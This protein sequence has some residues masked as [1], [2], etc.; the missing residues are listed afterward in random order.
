MGV[1]K[2][3]AWL[4]AHAPQATTVVKLD[5]FKGYALAV[6]MDNLIYKMLKVAQKQVIS[7]TD[8]SQDELDE[9][10]LNNLT[11]R[12][13]MAKISELIEHGITPVCVFD[14]PSHPLK[15]HKANKNRAAKEKLMSR[16]EEAKNA[17]RSADPLWRSQKLVDDYAK[18][19]KQATY[20]SSSFSSD[21]YHMLSALGIPV[22]KGGE[23]CVSHIEAKDAEGLCATLC[24][25]KYCIAAYTTDS[26]FHF[27]GGDTQITD[28][29]HGNAT[30][31]TLANILQQ[32]QITYNQ[33][34]DMCILLG[35]DFNPNIRGIALV[36]AW[37]KLQKYGSI[38]AMAL[39]EDVSVLNHK[40]VRALVTSTIQRIQFDPRLIKETFQSE[41]KE[42]LATH[43]LSSYGERIMRTLFPTPTLTPSMVANLPSNV[44]RL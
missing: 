24:I 12:M 4:E 27:Y 44:M 26:D 15:Q 3:S 21:L 35:N 28:I 14:G 10:E 19:L 25:N 23:P 16:L 11:R 2:F 42:I 6:D 43:K 41:Y 33:F 13:V 32:A 39:Y 37:K 5:M 36:N 22:L 38:D 29:S 18:Y 7:E 31:R 8:L 30:V 17:L 20:V 40:A 34:V 1:E 9:T